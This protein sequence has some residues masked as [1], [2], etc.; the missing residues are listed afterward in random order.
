MI[1][2]AQEDFCRYYGILKSVKDLVAVYVRNST[3]RGAHA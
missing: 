2:N 1:D 3:Q